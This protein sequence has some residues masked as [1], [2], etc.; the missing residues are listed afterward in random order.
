MPSPFLCPE[1]NSE[2]LRFAEGGDGRDN[3]VDLGRLNLESTLFYQRLR[4]VTLRL[5]RSR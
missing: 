5:A 3:K 2:K 1:P 4:Q